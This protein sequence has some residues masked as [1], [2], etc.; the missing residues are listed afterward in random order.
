MIA[1][2]IIT[3]FLFL[4][5]FP[6]VWQMDDKYNEFNKQPLIEWSIDYFIKSL[7]RCHFIPDNVLSIWL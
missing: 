5:Y 1:A 2:T 6:S 3:V 7:L 4:V